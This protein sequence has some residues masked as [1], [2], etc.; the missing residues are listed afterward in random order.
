ML[1]PQRSGRCVAAAGVAAFAVLLAGCA[2]PSTSEA[3]SRHEFERDKERCWLQTTDGLSF[4]CPEGPCM[5]TLPSRI[6]FQ[7]CMER[8]GWELDDLDVAAPRDPRDA[9]AEAWVEEEEE[10]DHD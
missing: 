10:R 1:R 6:E 7:R 9:P 2:G 3:V 8:R 5:V 4:Q